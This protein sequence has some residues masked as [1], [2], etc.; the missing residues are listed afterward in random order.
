MKITYFASNDGMGDITS[1]ACDYFRSWALAQ[2]RAEYPD[3]NIDVVSDQATY[4]V[5][6][7]SDDYAEYIAVNDFC[8]A[9]WDRCDWSNFDIG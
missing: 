7:D 5:H 2:L 1:S 8:S 3:A 9:L 6:C 4:S